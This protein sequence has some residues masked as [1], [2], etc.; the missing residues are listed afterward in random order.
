MIAVR[1]LRKQSVPKEVILPAV[2]V[3]KT[4]YAPYDLPADQRSCPKWEEMVKG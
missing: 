1:Q 3:D 4:N 2:V